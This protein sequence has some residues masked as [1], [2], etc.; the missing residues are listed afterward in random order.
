MH[1]L[2]R[3]SKTENKRLWAIHSWVGLYAGV[4]IAFLSVT[5]VA[6]LFRIEADHV[7]NPGLRTVES[8]GHKVPMTPVVEKIQALHPDKQLFE[9]ELPKTSDGT[10]NIRF[11]AKESDPLFPVLWEVFVHPYTGE[12]LGERNYYKTFNYFLR[13][14]HVRF[15]EA[16][17]GRQ[18]VGLAGLALL[19][20]TIT[21]F[22]IYGK[23]MKKQF[24]G[25]IRKQKLR[26]Q[27]A[28]LH[29]LIGITA[30]VFNLM[31]A[32]TGTW[33]GLQGYLQKWLSIERPNTYAIAEKPLDAEQDIQYVFNYDSVCIATTNNFP[34]LI[35]LHIRPSTNGDRTVTVLGNVP[36][37]VYER[38]NNKLVLDKLDYRMLFKYNINQGNFGDKVFYV[39]EALHF[40]D[41]GGITLKVLYSFLGITSGFLSITGF[42]VYLE[43]TRKKRQVKAGFIALRP[44][45]WR[46]G[47][48][49]IAFCVIMG[50]MSMIWGIGV[51]SLLVI[52]TFY[53]A[54]LFLLLR[55]I[56]LNLKWRLIN[57][58]KQTA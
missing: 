19:V 2:S 51:P 48:S 31:I 9:I 54:M 8:L 10:W 27:Q 15:Y 55:A 45:L 56:Y 39:Q 24:F 25:S 42:V 32:I 33:L 12:T 47:G 37:Q 5:G 49:I 35:P 1:G 29:K 44:M 41:F 30:L 17:F 38:S 3:K 4:A 57:L 11:V 16:W 58:K 34:Q 36:G 22:L 26:V 40:G 7:L 43:R 14:I 21:G 13:N 53:G 50:V 23:F 18:I 52:I 6:A 28:D 46:W 20:S